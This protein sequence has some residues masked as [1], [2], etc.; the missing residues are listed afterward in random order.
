[1]A[2]KKTKILEIAIIAIDTL[3]CTS[4]LILYGPWATFRN[5]WVTTAM[6]TMNHRY[7]AHIFYSDDMIYKVMANNV[8]I[9]TGEDSDISL[10]NK[11]NEASTSY[12]DR[13]E[14]QILE[15]NKG[16]DLYKVINISGSG[17]RGFLVAIYDHQKLS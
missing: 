8:V 11:D 14:K 12:A 15:R 16:N 1:V 5:F 3:L 2:L 13:Y 6:T 9:E 7:L 10:I 17:Y 4:L